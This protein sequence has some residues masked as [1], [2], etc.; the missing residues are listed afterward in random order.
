MNT[1]IGHARIGCAVLLS[2]FALDRG[3]TAAEPDQLEE[4]SLQRIQQ[5]AQDIN[6]AERVLRAEQAGDLTQRKLW[7]Q[8]LAEDQADTGQSRALRGQI[9]DGRRGWVGLEDAVE[10]AKTSKLLARYEAERASKPASIAGHLAMAEWCRRHQLHDQARGHLWAALRLDP[11]HAGAHTALGHVQVDGRWLTPAELQRDQQNQRRWAKAIREYGSQ[12]RAIAKQLTDDQPAV[13]EVARQQLFAIEDSAAILAVE[14][15]FTDLPS[16]AVIPACDWLSRQAHPDA[17]LTLARWSV[18][19]EDPRVRAAARRGL[20]DKPRIEYVPYLVDSARSQIIISSIPVYRPDGTLLGVRHVRAQEGR[21]GIDMQVEDAMQRQG[22]VGAAAT[23]TLS[24]DELTFGTRSPIRRGEIMRDIDRANRINSEITRQE[25]LR[26]NQ[27]LQR[28]ADESNQQIDQLNA[29]ISQTLSEAADAPPDSSPQQLW[30][31]WADYSE[32]EPAAVKLINS[33]YR[34]RLTD[35]AYVDPTSVIR[36]TLPTGGEC[37]IAGT[38]VHTR[39]GHKPIEELAVG[40]QVLAKDL[41]LGEFVW[42]TIVATTRQA[43]KET[44]VLKTD[45]GMLQCT[46]GHLFWVSGKGWTKA[47]EL[48]PG[49]LLHSAHEPAFV[50]TVKVA[51]PMPTYNLVTEHHHNYFV[52]A[53][54]ILSHDFDE[55]TAP[56]VKVPGLVE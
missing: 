37:F 38:I 5:L 26:V 8:R 39:R 52:G 34:T 2:W 29:R 3:L 14:S 11:Q 48:L 16:S 30:D 41:I 23:A 56:P 25:E 9:R 32:R 51:E 6:P 19:S 31:W 43:P 28:A 33:S 45:V 21:N 50:E 36:A 44:L 24:A 35:G 17:S 7:L 54:G 53:K 27:Q 20:R 1:S 4:P 49:D 22:S 18:L 55:P 47:R 15:V 42:D 13:A 40:D 10:R 46:G 12:L